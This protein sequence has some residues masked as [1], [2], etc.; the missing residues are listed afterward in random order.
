MYNF[1]LDN[2]VSID[3]LMRY[4]E[5]IYHEEQRA[6]RLNLVFSTILQHRETGEYRFFVP[7]NNN[8]IFVRPLYVSRRID[9]ERLRLRLRHK[10][11]LIDLLRNRPDTKWIPVLVTN[12]HYTIYSTVNPLGNGDLP[13]YLLNKDSIYPLVK[14]Q[15]TRKLYE[16][17]LCAFRCLVL[18]RTSTKND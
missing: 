15:H 6:F 13:D 16:D 4:A 1:P 10:D 14:N 2:D 9:L 7:Y 8:G 17:Q 11:I 5:D 12:G 3:Q 18:L